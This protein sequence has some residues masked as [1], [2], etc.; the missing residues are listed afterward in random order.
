MNY[1]AI[2]RE[3][4]TLSYSLRADANLLWTIF[5][6]P[7]TTPVA[8][9]AAERATDRMADQLAAMKAEIAKARRA[10]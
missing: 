8:L 7:W 4:R 6:P 1:F 3:A 2:F 5:S 10:A 9:E